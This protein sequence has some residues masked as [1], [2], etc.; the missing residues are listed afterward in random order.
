MDIVKNLT[1]LIN[2]KHEFLIENKNFIINYSKT[3]G[4]PN[5]TAYELNNQ[6]LNSI[7]G[8]RREFVLDSN[9][10]SNQIYQ[11][12]P[13][14]QIFSKQWSRG[15]LVPSF[16]MSWDKS[17][18]GSWYSTYKMSNIIPQNPKFNMGNWNKIERETY[19]IVKQN[20]S[21]TSIITGCSNFWSD[22]K[23]RVKKISSEMSNFIWIDDTIE[24]EYH[25]PSIMYQLVITPWEIF[26]WV[27]FNNQNQKI[28]KI[29]PATLEDI[30]GIRF[31]LSV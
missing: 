29:N 26:C 22:K 2:T 12:K 28:Y 5:W 9:L 6:I 15:H 17:R 14:S 20:S 3:L 10:I 1:K 16:L 4:R 21:P 11:L 27:G 7:K 31:D 24:F 25:I 19:Q 18:N 23:T 13:N 30:I 8:G